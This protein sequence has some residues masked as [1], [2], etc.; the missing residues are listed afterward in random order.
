[1]VV[2]VGLCCFF[3]VLGAWQRSG[4][5]QGDK[6]A[7]TLNR[8]TAA[9]CDELVGAVRA[10]ARR[11][12]LH[13][14]PQLRQAPLPAPRV[15][16]GPLVPLPHPSGNGGMYI[17]RSTGRSGRAATRCSPARRSTRRRTTRLRRATAVPEE[18][19]RRGAVARGLR[20]GA[21][22]DRRVV[23]GGNWWWDKHVRAY[24]KVNRR[25][26]GNRYWN[27]M[28]MNVGVGGFAAVV[29][30]RKSWVTNVMPTIAELS[31]LG[32]DHSTFGSTPPPLPATGPLVDTTRR[33]SSQQRWST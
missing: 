18:A 24:K 25:L 1:M 29:F 4:Y 23:R 22:A 8:Q 19:E 14:C 21:R 33:R 9:A 13:R 10:G 20:R 7:M 31:T 30:S 27:I 6:I 12:G 3:Y 2:A 26:D 16:H 17:W 28:D 5:G 32:S 15:R 11:A